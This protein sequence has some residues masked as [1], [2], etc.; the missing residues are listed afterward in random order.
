[1]DPSAKK[2]VLGSDPEKT[3]TPTDGVDE[4]TVT[5]ALNARPE[6]GPNE[7]ETENEASPSIPATTTMSQDF[8]ELPRHFGVPRSRPHSNAN[9]IRSQEIRPASSNNRPIYS[10]GN[11]TVGSTGGRSLPPLK[12]RETRL[13]QK[14]A[15]P[16]Q[17]LGITLG[18]PMIV[19]FDIVVPCIIYYTWYD[20]QKGHWK[21]ECRTRF[22]GQNPCPIERPQFNRDILGS[23]IASF[24]VG[25]LWILL[26]RV[27]RLLFHQEECAPLLSRSRWELDATSWVYLVAM[28]LA[29]I[30]FVIGSSLV[31]PKLYLYGP[32]FIMGFLGILMVITVDLPWWNI[33]IGINSQPRGSGLRPFIYYAA[34]DFIAV[35]GLQDREFRVRYNDRYETNKMF[36]QFFFYLTLWWL[37]GVCVYIG[38]VSAVIWTLPFHYAFGL[39]LGVL[40]AYIVVWAGVTYVWT[41]IEMKREHRAY[42]EGKFDV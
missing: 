28:V 3:Q 26:A 16:L 12:R 14:E 42:E 1:M 6:N 27:W 13:A 8:A 9:S 17:H 39:S 31:I 4:N 10:T 30:P 35:D 41:N 2:E 40:F 33:P 37:L 23:A 25:E 20:S 32:S 19:I 34:E 24:G 11:T 38:C 21:D 36:R 5:G 18:L 29:L 7:K 22:P 15:H